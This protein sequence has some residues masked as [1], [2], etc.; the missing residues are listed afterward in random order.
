MKSPP[1]DGYLAAGC[2][3]A[4]AL[5]VASCNP[6]QSQRADASFDARMA[7]PAYARSGPR[8]VIDESHRN[9]HTASGHYR[10]FA[11]LIGNDGYQVQPGRVALTPDNLRQIDILVV[12]NAQGPENNLEWEAAFATEEVRAIRDW[13]FGGGSLLLIA[14]HFPMGGAAERL[15]QA[16]GV[17]MT[18]GVTDDTV[19]CVPGDP[20]SI[21]Y[22][23]EN[24]LLLSH[25][26]TDG[27]RAEESVGRVVTFTGQSIS[28]PAGAVPFL[29]LGATARDSR[30]LP[31][32]IVT[33]GTN[34]QITPQYADPEPAVGRAQGIA[35]EL[36][37]GRVVILGEAAMVTAQIA[38]DGH[39]FG[40]NVSG[41]DNRKLALNIMHWLSRLN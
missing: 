36:G 15:S 6:S 31:P 32:K 22:S 25:P 30:P 7:H 38:G 5:L 18:K 4:A 26:I 2:L 34:T 21:V 9:F 12:S 14:D 24:G 19:N 13:V 41:N 8:V 11:Q 3:I 35:L 10:P 33:S 16:F 28:V 20:T 37:K 23:R 40:M 39:P 17:E 1:R 29:K 27:R